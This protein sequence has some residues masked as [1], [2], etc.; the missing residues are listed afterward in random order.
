MSLKDFFCKAEKDKKRDILHLLGQPEDR[1]QKCVSPRDPS[2]WGSYLVSSSCMSSKL[3]L[4]ADDGLNPRDSDMG[5]RHPQ[6]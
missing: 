1:S 5:C 2:T 6:Q 3:N 4:E